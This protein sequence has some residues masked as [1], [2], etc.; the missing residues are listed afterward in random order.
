MHHSRSH[1]VELL[2][3]STTSSSETTRANLPSSPSS[4]TIEPMDLHH[5]TIHGNLCRPN[6]PLQQHPQWPILLWPTHRFPLLLVCYKH[7]G[8]LLLLPHCY[9]ATCK[10]TV[11]PPWITPAQPTTA[12]SAAQAWRI[13]SP[14]HNAPTVPLTSLLLLLFLSEPLAA[15]R[16]PFSSRTTTPRQ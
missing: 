13:P 8:L 2:V 11:A 16:A 10:L 9:P 1:M 7:P 4:H 6:S 14:L 5:P 12:S 15:L 3:R